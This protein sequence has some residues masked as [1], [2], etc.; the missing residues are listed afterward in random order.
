MTGR[1]MWWF[2]G[3]LPLHFLQVFEYEEANFRLGSALVSL[4]VTVGVS[5]HLED[6][7]WFYLGFLFFDCI[8]PRHEKIG[9]ELILHHCIAAGLVL[10]TVHQ[11]SLFLE[12]EL[13]A[14]NFITHR[15]LI[16]ERTTPLL[17]A[18]WI[19]REYGYH[20]AAKVVF[21]CLILAWIPWRLQPSYDI[22]MV[23]DMVP[24]TFTVITLSLCAIQ[25]YWF[26]KLCLTF[27]KALVPEN[28]E[29]N[30]G[31]EKNEAN[32]KNREG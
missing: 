12:N 14:V 18:S 26:Y 5:H 11:Q 28:N 16:F 4:A 17:H 10:I 23:I 2:F 20:N 22:F 31:S 25:W 7:L 9:L 3:S 29:S 1:K 27:A 19:F 30:G 13:F 21:I 6:C 8:K 15:F 32:P 24:P